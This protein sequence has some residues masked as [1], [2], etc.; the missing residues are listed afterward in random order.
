MLLYT[1][2]ELAFVQFETR[3]WPGYR[4]F[5][6][7][8][9]AAI[10]PAHL[11][12]GEPLPEQSEARVGQIARHEGSEQTAEILATELGCGKVNGRSSQVPVRS[13]AL[14]YTADDFR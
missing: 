10:F 1:A 9:T 3:H 4:G 14:R 2:G 11:K 5:S 7:Y 12:P 6:N 8:V 13:R